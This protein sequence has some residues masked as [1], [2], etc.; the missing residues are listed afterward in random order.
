[1]KQKSK[2]KLKTYW[3]VEQEFIKEEKRIME[4]KTILGRDT[5]LPKKMVHRKIDIQLSKPNELLNKCG[6][7]NIRRGWIKKIDSK[8]RYHIYVYGDK[9]FL[10]KDE[11]LPNKKHKA[12]KKNLQNEVDYILQNIIT[13]PKIPRLVKGR[14]KNDVYAD[15]IKVKKALENLPKIKQKKS[16]LQR[17]IS[18]IW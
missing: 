4:I 12:T 9:I 14:K 1:M 18:Y 2:T 8:S 6:Y 5:Q 17:I 16:L 10:H 3:D 13:H 11:L 15:P 7:R